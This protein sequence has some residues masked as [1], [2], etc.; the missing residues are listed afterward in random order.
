MKTVKNFKIISALIAVL[1][2]SLSFGYFNVGAGFTYG[3]TNSWTLRVG[4]EDET[5]SMNADYLINNSWNIAG[6]VYF[7]TEVGFKVGPFI[8]GTYNISANDFSV[9]Y[10]PVIGFTTKQIFAQI[11]YLTDFTQFQDISKGIFAI[12]RFYVPDPPGMKMRDKLYLE[13]QYYGGNFKIIVGLLE[14]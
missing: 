5:F 4:I 10:G 9:M 12:L 7:S 8:F 1:L 3:T 2:S 14:P 6:G 11:G 13:G